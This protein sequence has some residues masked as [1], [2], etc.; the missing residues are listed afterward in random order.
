MGF[1]LYNNASVAARTALANGV[2]RV[3]IVDWDVHHGNGTQA[4]FYDDPRVAY[5]SSHRSPFYP[6]TGDAD[7]TGTGAGLGTTHNVPFSIDTPR[8]E[9]IAR[10]THELTRFADN[11]RPELVILSAGFDAHR[12][13]PVG[14]L[15]WEQEDFTSLTELTLQ[16]ANI[17]A[18]G[19]LVSLLEG[20]YNP[21]VL[22]GSV[23]RH[24]RALLAADPAC[25]V[26]N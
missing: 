21:G 24:I 13:D 16:I 11:V 17:H 8:E 26:G 7:E 12:D 9:Q 14:S 15:G 10:I 3:L 6:G 5:F 18:G 23:E 20:G 1:C 22:A 25:N 2:S 4:I 19:R